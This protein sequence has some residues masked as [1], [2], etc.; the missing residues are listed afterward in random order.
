LRKREIQDEEGY[1]RVEWVRDGDSD[2]VQGIPG[3]PPDVRQ[4][5]WDGIQKDLHNELCRRNLHSYA[6]VMRSGSALDGAILAA[7]KKKL[8]SLYRGGG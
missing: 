2:S 6:D 3:G 5:D 7:L 1:L 8:L 4:L